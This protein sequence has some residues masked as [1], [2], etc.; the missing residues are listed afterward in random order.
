MVILLRI[1]YS[2]Q[3]KY[4]LRAVLVPQNLEPNDECITVQNKQISTKGD[5]G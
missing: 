4:N 1:E 5:R 2:N 3:I